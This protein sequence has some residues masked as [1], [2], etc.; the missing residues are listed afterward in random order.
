MTDW[1]SRL[2]SKIVRVSD[3]FVVSFKRRRSGRLCN[4]PVW[5]AKD[6]C[7]AGRKARD[8]MV[9]LRLEVG[10]KGWREYGISRMT[11]VLYRT[12]TYG[13]DG[14]WEE[15]VERPQDLNGRVWERRRL[16]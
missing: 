8:R 5:A 6:P 13:T 9:E 11:A 7:D 16:T 2:A 1:L 4:I 12:V 15:W 14:A 3:A 10:P